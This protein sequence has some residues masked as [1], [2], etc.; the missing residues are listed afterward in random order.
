MDR[1]WLLTSTFYGNWLPGDSRG[2]VSRVRDERP[3]DPDTTAR[4]KHKIPGTPYDEDI[5]GLRGA[6]EEELKGEPIRVNLEQAQA[7][8]T[9]FQETSVARGWGLLVAAV[10]AN[11]VHLVVGVHGDPSPRKVLGDFKA[12]GSRALTMGW[13]RPASDTWWTSRGSKRKLLGRRAVVDAVEYVRDQFQPL[14]IWVNPQ[15]ETLLP[16]ET[17]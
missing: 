7:L 8:F 1:Y 10:M 6:A 4:L 12:Y 9:Q 17:A 15:L 14:I 2:F 5:P 16:P 13:G 11:H 3:D